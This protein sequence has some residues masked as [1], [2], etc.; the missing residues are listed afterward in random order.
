MWYARDEKGTAAYE[1]QIQLRDEIGR[2]ILRARLELKHAN[3]VLIFP[4]MFP[5]PQCT[6]WLVR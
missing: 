4:M 3:C 1:N 2:L 6:A 5:M